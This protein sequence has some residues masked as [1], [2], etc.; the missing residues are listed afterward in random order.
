MG[1]S[2]IIL[3]AG[4]GKRMTS[5]VSK[6]LHPIGGISL[7]E[8]VVNTAQLLRACAVYVVYSDRKSL[9]H[10]KFNHLPVHWVEQ[11]EQ[12]GTGHAVLQV[13]PFCNE[14]DQVLVLYGDVP[15]ISAKT[16]QNLLHSTPSNSI[17]LIVAELPDPTGLGRIIRN[18]FG[19]II[20]IVEHEDANRQ[21]LKICEINTGIMTTSSANLKRWLPRL[22]NNNQQKEYYLTDI[23]AMAVAEGCHVG[24]VIVHCFEEVQGI[25]NRWDL[26][27]LERYFQQSMAK[28]LALA[29]AT[30]MDPNRIDIRGDN[31][32]VSHDVIIDVNVILEGKI[33]LGRNVRIGPN[34]LLKNVTIGE[35]TEIL[36][37]TIIEDTMIGAQC[38][39]GPFTRI[40]PGSI[41]EEGV[42]V[43]NFVEVKKSILGMGSKANHLTYLGD[44]TIGKDVNIGAGTITCNYDGANK[45]P[46]K[47]E[48]GAFI[49][50]NAAL[51]A[52]IIIGKNATIGAGSTITQDVPSNH[53]TLAR[54]RQHTVKNW[55][56]SQK[57]KIK[58]EDR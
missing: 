2:V 50:S 14:N 39:V 54:K 28:K 12:L 26:I 10:K 31:V 1:L 4:K 8:R 15:L 30:I 11:N 27:K 46:T 6:V 20:D 49:G 23:V 18:E 3:A 34:V 32:H 44:A 57:G 22:G 9:V 13:I 7:L 51:V 42:K 36:S 56:R 5:G 45:W 41:L 21:Q 58:K 35:N 48:D 40:R 29:G 43:G 25:N 52:P 24:G 53:L 19:N 38:S 17:G 16:L 33:R 55:C 47:I 37:N